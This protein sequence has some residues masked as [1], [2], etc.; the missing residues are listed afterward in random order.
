MVVLNLGLGETDHTGGHI[1]RRW[2]NAT[3]AARKPV[4]NPEQS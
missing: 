1:N 4:A 2:A 3:L